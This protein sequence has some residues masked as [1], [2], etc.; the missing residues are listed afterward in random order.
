[1]QSALVCVHGCEGE[2]DVF[3]PRFECSNCKG[4]VDVKHD[5]AA[6]GKRSAAEW[7]RVL[8]QRAASTFPLDRSGVWAHREW[9]MPM[10]DAGDVVTAGEG[11]TPLVAYPAFAR[12][13]KLAEVFIKQCGHTQTGSFKDL[14]MTVL[15]S[16]A[17]A[18]RRRGRD[19]RALICASTGDTSAALAAYG[20]MAQIPVVVLLPAGKISPAQLVQPLAHGAHV[21]MLDGD[22]DQC[23]SVVQEVSRLPGMFLANSKNPLRLEGQKTVAFEIAWDLGWALPDFVVVP[24]GNL[25]NVAALESGFS[26]LYELGLVNRVPRL[27]AAQVD[28]ANPLFRAY[29][30]GLSALE[31]LA[32][33]DTLASAIRIG[34]PVSFPRARQ[35]LLRSQGVVTSCSEAELLKAQVDADRAG[36]FV[37]PHTAAALAG[38]RALRDDDTIP[39]GATAVVVSTAHGLKF[40]EQKAQ[41][42]AGELA[43]NLSSLQRLRNPPIVVDASVE[44]VR[45]VLESRSVT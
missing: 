20:A 15:V 23:M 1:M 19:I 39:E 9:V 42:H 45:S 6:F 32:A 43:A 3:E 12:E 34:N 2:F 27:V 16:M 10:L 17:N 25:G 30:K 37:C 28:A 4:L 31:P 41:F 22:F 8:A 44:S 13:T 26:L 24:S 14:G 40:A 18:M 21:L 29:Q 38:L 33:E 7:H 11:R 36:F 35:A 5:A